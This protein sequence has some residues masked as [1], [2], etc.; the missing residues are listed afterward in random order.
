[1]EGVP[2]TI[3]YINQIVDSKRF[4]FGEIYKITNITTNTCYVGQTVTHRKNHER[5]RPFGSMG[6]FKDHISEAMCNTKKL[7][8]PYLNAAIRKYKPDNFTVDL[9][10]RCQ[11]NEL[12]DKEKYW[13]NELKTIYP[14]GYNLTR[15]GKTTE[16]IIHTLEE[17]EQFVSNKNP[18]W[19]F[20]KKST[21]T[22]IKIGEANKKWLEENPNERLLQGTKAREQHLQ[23]KLEKFAGVTIEK[24]NQVKYIKRRLKID[25][26]FAKYQV[27]IGEISTDFCSKHETEVELFEHAKKFV[28]Q[29]KIN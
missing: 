8:C 23:R 24:D 14:F 11:L 9:L 27:V 29:L 28:E 3:E 1:M 7:Q 18:N 15:G 21:A 22:K 16:K 25:G 13:I 12:D 6:R 10:C 4:V 19:R 2:P 17:E 5:Y 20:E 26:S